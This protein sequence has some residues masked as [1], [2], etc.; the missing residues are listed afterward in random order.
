[1]PKSGP[2]GI[3][4]QSP[5]NPTSGYRALHTRQA[6]LSARLCPV[7]QGMNRYGGGCVRKVLSLAGCQQQNV[8]E[9]NYGCYTLYLPELKITRK[10]GTGVGVPRRGE[11]ELHLPV[12]ACQK[13]VCSQPLRQDVRLMRGGGPARA[14]Y[15]LYYRP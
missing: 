13:H 7:S 15:L 12:L 14:T 5:Y 3:S 6:A 11:A 4:E 10:R 9:C 2:G 8:I 1:M